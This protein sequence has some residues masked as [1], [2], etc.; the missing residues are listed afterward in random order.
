M[1]RRRI[2]IADVRC[3][4]VHTRKVPILIDRNE[5]LAQILS[6]TVFVM[7]FGARGDR[8]IGFQAT[9]RRGFR[10]VDVA[11]RTLPD[12]LFLLTPTIMYELR[13]DSY[14]LGL[15]AVGSRELVTAVAVGGH[16]L[17]LFPVTV[18]T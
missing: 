3:V 15:R 18:E 12:V 17:L 6:Q 8:H 13:G 5:L 10:D 1:T 14:R 9:Q 16:W 2:E 4:T 11:R 7:A